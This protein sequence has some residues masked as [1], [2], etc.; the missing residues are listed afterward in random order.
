MSDAAPLGGWELASVTGREVSRWT[1]AGA[2]GDAFVCDVTLEGQYHGET[3]GAGWQGRDFA[4]A[5]RGLE[6]SRPDLD[7]LAEHLSEWLA[8][9]PAALADP[10]RGLTCGMGALFDQRLALSI[11]QRADVVSGGRPVATLEFAVGRLRGDFRYVVDGTSLKRFADGI[12]LALTS[13]PSP[14]QGEGRVRV[15]RI[16]DH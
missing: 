6:L 12:H 3:L 5:M 1:I 4:L 13:A 15:D 11:G 16:V 14:S 2:S 8:L 7:R 9:P 10:G